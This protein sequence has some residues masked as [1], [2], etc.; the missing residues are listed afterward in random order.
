MMK[1][2]RAV[3]S[4]L[5]MP[6]FKKPKLKI[7]GKAKDIIK[8][9]VKRKVNISPVFFRYSTLV[10]AFGRKVL[11]ITANNN[12]IM[13]PAASTRQDKRYLAM[14]TRDLLTGRLQ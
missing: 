10:A 8:I 2:K 13:N 4:R 14:T 5:T 9:K 6:P 11:R 3:I 7:S 12:R 1:K